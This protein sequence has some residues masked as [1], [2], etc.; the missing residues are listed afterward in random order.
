MSKLTEVYATTATT[1]GV[2]AFT[3]KPNRSYLYVQNHHATTVLYIYI[4][5]PPSGTL[6]TA[7]LGW[8]ALDPSKH[9]IYELSGSVPSDEVWVKCSTGTADIVLIQA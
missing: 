7:P 3:V 2:K 6:P 4:G 8:I 1:T 9:D 5:T